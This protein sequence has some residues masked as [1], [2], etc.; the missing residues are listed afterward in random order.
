MCSLSL[1]SVK[2]KKGGRGMK[3][4]YLLLCLVVLLTLS[5]MARGE[6][7]FESRASEQIALELTVY[8]SD[9]ALIKETR[10]IKLA[11]GEGEL[12]FL[13]VASKIIPTTLQVSSLTFPE[14]FRVLEQAYE[15]D[16]LTPKK[17]LDE[18]VGKRIKI[19]QWHEFQDR[20]EVI[21]AL[22]LSTTQGEIYQIEGEI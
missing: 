4:R 7:G 17:L 3:G 10:E 8:N 5:T 2:I 13:D 1:V 21:E 11:V 12:R 16:L 18:Y 15:Y 9:V 22:L 6:S 20:K 19:I 14:E